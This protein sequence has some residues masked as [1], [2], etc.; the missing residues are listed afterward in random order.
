MNIGRLSWSYLTAKPLN[1]ILNVV[2]F[3]FGI[4]III[5]LL[6]FST[7][8]EQK[9]T[10]NSKG[11]DMV[12]GAKGSPMQIILCSIYQID[13]PTGNINLFEAE[14]LT[15]N[16]QIKQAI[17]LSLG[18]SYRGYRIVG[19]TPA[20]LE[21]YGMELEQGELWSESLEVVLGSNAAQLLGLRIGDRFASQHGMAE[22]GH[23]HD[24]HDFVVKG[25]LKQA[26]NVVDNLILS[27]IESIW[28]VHEDEHEHGHES[29]GDAVI[30]SKLV[31]GVSWHQE[32]SIRQVTSMLIKFRSPMGAVMLPRFINE[33]TNMQ[34]ALPA[35]ETARLFSMIGIGIDVV[36][37]FAFIVIF[38]AGL[39]IFIALYN[40]L[41][42]RQYD[43]AIMRSMGATRG[44]LFTSILL[45]GLWITVIGAF[46]GL[47]AGHLT[48]ELI[49]NAVPESDRSG[50]TGFLFLESEL[51]V[52]LASL[53]IGFL[54]ALIPAV[55][56]FKTDISRI[57]ARG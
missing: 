28:I 12:V 3:T 51:W 25:I 17:P 43:L 6:L 23:G 29:H 9:L 4:A 45:E 18:D 2:L 26:N 48:V 7:Q 27:D 57:L 34:A 13:F 33:N 40:S 39:S 35:F 5:V 11:I 10:S 41:K 31:P 24:D 55:Q 19:T 37:G 56:A 8:V 15:N 14:R 38:I 22:G 47:V 30:Q 21:H 49:N 20:Y 46:L 54:A 52:L 16:R 53:V 32:D 1:T 36:Q 50:I 42:E 44:K